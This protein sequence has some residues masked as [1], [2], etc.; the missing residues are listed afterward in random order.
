[1][2]FQLEQQFAA[3][4]TAVEEAYLDPELL[5]RFSAL[6]DLGRPELLE[7]TEDDHTV[8]RRVR[9]RF[10]GDLPPAV[11]AVIDPARLT[12][13]EESEHD[14]RTHR[15]GFRVRPDHYS[16]LLRCTGT[17]TLAPTSTGTI[18]VTAG[19]L[20]V[21][22]PFVGGKAERAIVSGWRDHAAAEARL[23]QAWLEER[24]V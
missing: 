21:R 5:S 12:W 16:S 3:S 14:R 19:A 15:A 6:S 11:T 4:L 23:V 8:R 17:V 9:Y 24:L 13:V 7:H 20:H 2:Q 1:V 10:A 22:F 18:R